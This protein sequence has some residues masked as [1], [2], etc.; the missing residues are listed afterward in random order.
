M[1]KSGLTRL[2]KLPSSAEVALYGYNAM[3]AGKTVAVHGI[4]NRIMA[5][6]GRFVPRKLVTALVRKINRPRLR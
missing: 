2:K 3:M 4:A 6:S 1:G 5:E